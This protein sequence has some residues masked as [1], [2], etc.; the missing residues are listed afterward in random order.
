MSE[1]ERGDLQRAVER[2]ENA[3]QQFVGSANISTKATQFLDDAA[4]RLEREARQRK[5]RS[6]R[7]QARAARKEA[8]QATYAKD[9][10]DEVV[11]RP[12]QRRRRRHRRHRRFDESREPGYRTTKLYRDT[13]RQKVAGVCAGLARYFGV[14][15]WVVRCVGVTGIIFMPSIVIPAYLIGMFVIPKMPSPEAAADL[16]RT[17][18]DHRSPAPELGAKLSP[19]NSL[20]T[21][22][23]ALDQVELK[24][25][26][27]ESYV[28]SGQYE[29]QR[30]LKRIDT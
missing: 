9:D 26:R 27:M 7:R 8:Q 3:V 30:E 15:T 28:T 18:Q 6:E 16:A 21:A 17:P 24:L 23:A 10:D 1:H 5:S 4:E 14:E 13:R 20:S 11:S 29:L 19:R 12:E 22:Q 2:L 25:R